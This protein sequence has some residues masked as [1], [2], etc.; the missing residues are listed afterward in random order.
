[1]RYSTLSQINP[2]G[3]CLYSAVADQLALL[4]RI[5]RSQ[6][7]YATTRV[8]AANYIES[9]AEDFLPFLPAIGGEDSAGATEAGLIS[10]QQFQQYCHAVRDSAVWGGEPEIQALCRAFNTPIYVVQGGAP[11]VV[12]HQPPGNPD[13]AMRGN[14]VWLSY[15]RRMYGLGEVSGISFGIETL[16]L[17]VQQHY[18]SLRPVSIA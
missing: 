7:T 15:H 4:G 11:P 12:V 5:S 9:H 14:G 3:H 17:I 6:A 2:D 8:M 18:N 10:P 16:A 1:M 13:N